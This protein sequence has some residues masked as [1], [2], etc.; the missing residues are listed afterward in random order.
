M[1][2]EPWNP[3]RPEQGALAPPGER[4]TVHAVWRFCHCRAAFAGHADLAGIKRLP[5]RSQRHT[6]VRRPPV[7]RSPVLRPP[8]RSR[9][10]PFIPGK[11]GNQG[12]RR[13]VQS[14]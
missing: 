3:D 8:Y 2:A 5:R 6:T 12:S 10:Y 11:T 9:A 4:R 1:Q 14:S 13:S 7:A